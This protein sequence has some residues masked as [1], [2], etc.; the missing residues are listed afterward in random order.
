MASVDISTKEE[1]QEKIPDDSGA[2][3]LVSQ[4]MTVS[5]NDYQMGRIKIKA[6]SLPYPFNSSLFALGIAHTVAK[7]KG[8]AGDVFDRNR[9]ILVSGSGDYGDS[10]F[11][12]SHTRL[13]G[14][15]TMLHPYQTRLIILKQ[16]R[17]AK[18]QSCL[19]HCLF[20]NDNICFVCSTGNCL[21]V[22]R[23]Q[24]MVP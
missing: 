2:V 7:S 24:I 16:S 6:N 15:R 11:Q 1:K 12:D 3:Y 13:I 23:A 22:S 20:D 10:H 18:N 17:E 14:P 21:Y 9:N 19:I 8:E 4:N 5:V